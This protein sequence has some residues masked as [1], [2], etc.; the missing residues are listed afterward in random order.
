[1][2]YGGYGESYARNVPRPQ[3]RPISIP[4]GRGLLIGGDK[5][6]YD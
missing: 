5:V 1:M 3:L 6:R 2:K 4:D